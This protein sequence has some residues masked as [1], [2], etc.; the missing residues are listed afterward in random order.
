MESARK[1]A[2]WRDRL[3]GQI[4]AFTGPRAMAQ[5][6]GNEE[7]AVSAGE[8]SHL[9]LAEL[10]VPSSSAS[11]AE[12]DHLVLIGFVAGGHL[13]T[14]LL[15]PDTLRGARRVT[16]SGVVVRELP[17]LQCV[18]SLDWLSVAVYELRRTERSFRVIKSL[19]A[20]VGA[21]RAAGAAP[22][23]LGLLQLVLDRIE[24][25]VRAHGM[26]R[27]LGGSG[28]VARATDGAASHHAIV[29]DG[30]SLLL[31]YGPP[32]ERQDVRR[33]IEDLR[34]KKAQ[35]Q[36]EP[37]AG[38]ERE[39]YRSYLE[40]ETERRSKEAVQ[41]LYGSIASPSL[42]AVAPIGLEISPDL[43]VH[44]DVSE[45]RETPFRSLLTEL[46]QSIHATYQV[47]IPGIRI[48]IEASRAAG[49]YAVLLDEVPIAQG[50]VEAGREFCHADERVLEELGF[51]GRPNQHPA[52]ASSGVWVSPADAVLLRPVGLT[53][54]RVEEVIAAHLRAVWLANLPRFFGIDTLLNELDS[55]RFRQLEQCPGGVP[56]FR[57]VVHTLLEERLHAPL[58]ELFDEYRSRQEAPAHEL[59]ETLRLLPGVLS[60]IR[61]RVS[62]TLLVPVPDSIIRPIRAGVSYEGD[63]ARLQ[64][65]PGVCVELR[66]ELRWLL[67]DV[68]PKKSLVVE[69]WRLRAP[70]RE[71]VKMEF[72]GVDVVARRELEGPADGQ[73]RDG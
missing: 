68:S 65:A 1:L 16:A 69:D 45:E 13:G 70:L 17:L 8:R 27:L 66:P 20:A 64:L 23:A 62:G 7:R 73:V 33:Y 50:L 26:Q 44:L 38:Q 11:P 15:M 31:R 51:F 59:G 40:K 25:L 57:D 28:Q 18:R 72:Q 14:E 56:R 21:V 41:A 49:S 39:S 32:L 22:S 54:S 71:L 10:K 58:S 37:G 6:S 34:R 42:L 52:D 35:A 24:L 4:A 2:E 43:E 48:R 30:A 53:L 55:I 61:Q 36:G 67:L 3:L 60:A 19:E 46:R 29:E 9:S 5:R 12:L 47:K 63:W